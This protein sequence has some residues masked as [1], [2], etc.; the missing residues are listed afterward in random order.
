MIKTE[1]LE[2]GLN[3]VKTYLLKNNL[4]H[5]EF[6]KKLTVTSDRLYVDEIQIAT[7]ETIGS[8][9]LFTWNEFKD[10]DTHHVDI[11]FSDLNKKLDV[12]SLVG[13]V[14]RQ[15][16]TGIPMP[17]FYLH[18]IRSR[19]SYQLIGLTTLVDVQLS[20]GILI[21]FYPLLEIQSKLE[22][23]RTTLLGRFDMRQEVHVHNIQ[24][25]VVTGEI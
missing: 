3:P 15:S 22:N 16:R 21:D 17:I 5:E 11:L 12:S 19:T 23:L 7:Y 14:E 8:N 6:V 20:K 9:Y 18:H 4:L 25:F 13:A 2:V 24:G 10:R 1:T